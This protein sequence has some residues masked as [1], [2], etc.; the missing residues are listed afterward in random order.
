MHFLTFINK[1]LDTT[2]TCKE[3][4]TAKQITKTKHIMVTGRS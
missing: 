2:C 1:L 4:K 3:I